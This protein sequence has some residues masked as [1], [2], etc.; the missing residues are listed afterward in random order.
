LNISQYD[1]HRRRILSAF[2]SLSSFSYEKSPFF[3]F[4]HIVSPHPPFVFGENGETI[5]PVGPFSIDDGDD[6][7]GAEKAGI[8]NYITGYRA[9]LFF[10]NKKIK[11]TVDSILA[12]SKVPPIIILQSDHGP[13][14]FFDWES[15]EV[16]Y[17]KESMS[18]LNAVYL[19]GGDYHDF[20]PGISPVNTFIALINHITGSKKQFLKDKSFYSTWKRP[21]DFVPFN[22]Q[23]YSKT[24][25]GIDSKKVQGY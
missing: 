10:I 1:L 21:Y 8:Q 2:Q 23:S 3:V 11:E 24:L 4:S 13:R 17:L 15:A 19:P 5:R 9:Q 6:L 14:A 25:S 16:S 12:N 18:V 20:Y 7:H 22:P